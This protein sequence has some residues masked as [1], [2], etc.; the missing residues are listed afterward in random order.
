APADRAVPSRESPAPPHRATRRT[1]ASGS[2]A[3]RTPHSVAGSRPA[4][5]SVNAASVMGPSSSQIRPRPV[6]SGPAPGPAWLISMSIAGTSYGWPSITA[7]RT[8]DRISGAATNSTRISATSSGSPTG[9]LGDLPGLAACADRGVCSVAGSEP[10][11][12]RDGERTL[13]VPA[14]AARP[15]GE[16][17]VEQGVETVFR[18][19]DDPPVDGAVPRRGER[20]AG[21]EPQG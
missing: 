8:A 7:R 3:A 17:G 15:G 12:P 4:T 19:R 9:P 1:G 10:P 21:R 18:H 2:P 5:R 14:H 20:R 11:V 13:G 6:S 16:D